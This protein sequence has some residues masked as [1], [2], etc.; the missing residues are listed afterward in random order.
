MGNLIDSDTYG[1]G[2]NDGQIDGYSKGWRDC[3]KQYEGHI[4]KLVAEIRE[5]EARVNV[6][7][8]KVDERG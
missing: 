6:A 3:E 2:Y 8:R 5:M 4:A 1:L 7:T